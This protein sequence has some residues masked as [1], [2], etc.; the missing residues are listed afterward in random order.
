[1]LRV[2]V[3]AHPGARHERVV[4]LAGDE[5]GVWVRQRPV[6]GKANAAIEACLASALGLRPRQVEVVA[7]GTSRRKIV[8]LDLPDLQV[9]R[10]RLLAHPVRSD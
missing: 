6:E 8:A 5:L 3:V 10:E 7:G 2:P 1:M 9:L 4:L